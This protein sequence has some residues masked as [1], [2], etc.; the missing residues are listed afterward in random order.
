MGGR[1]R[2]RRVLVA[3]ARGLRA[4]GGDPKSLARVGLAAV[5]RVPRVLRWLAAAGGVLILTAGMWSM[6]HRATSEEQPLGVR[7]GPGAPF[8]ASDQVWTA[9]QL[10]ASVICEVGGGATLYP[11]NVDTQPE[12]D[13]VDWRLVAAV[14]QVS[15]LHA[16]GAGVNAFGDT[17]PR[18]VGPLERSDTDGGGWDG[19]SSADARVGPLALWP[20][21]VVAEGL[22]GNADD[23][24][25]PHNVWDAV[26]TTAAALCVR[27]ASGD[28]VGALLDWRN[29]RDWADLVLGAWD[30]IAFLAPKGVGTVPWG[31]PLAYTPRAA[32]GGGPVLAALLD[33]MEAPSS[34]VTCEGGICGVK[35]GFVPPDVSGWEGL[36]EA[37][38]GAPVAVA[39]WGFTVAGDTTRHARIHPWT[40]RLSWLFPAGTPPQPRWYTPPAWWAFTLPPSSP[41]W[42]EPAEGYWLRIP[43]AKGTTVYAPTAG[44]AEYRGGRCLTILDRDGSRWALCGVY[45]HPTGT[46]HR[47][48][49][50]SKACSATGTVGR[51]PPACRR[52][53][54]W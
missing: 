40:R 6:G 3:A 38:F 22:D 37:G 13:R 43:A 44:I 4:A 28:P 54:C 49:A 45:A 11:P 39:N 30:D 9:Y 35:L 48:P 20:A 21:E 53:R 46:S 47:S 41:L 27:G 34:A 32:G 8:G 14:G 15:S 29:D 24:V 19:S 42:T 36:L 51:T 33:R 26:A 17:S 16:Q 23:I 50:P 5:R 18:L 10:A 7:A 2:L 12:G 52:P 25:D 31:A 1:P